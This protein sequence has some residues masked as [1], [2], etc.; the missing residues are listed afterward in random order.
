MPNPESKWD[1]SSIRSRG[2]GV[3]G[4]SKAIADWGEFDLNR[5]Y[6]MKS[7]FYAGMVSA[8]LVTTVMAQTGALGGNTANIERAVTAMQSKLVEQ[9][10][11]IHMH[12]ELGNREVRTS[13]IV[14]ERLRAL[15]FDEV[16]TNVAG[17]G[18]VGLLKGGKPGPVVAVRADMDALPI[19]ETNAVPYKSLVPGVKHACGHDAH[20]TIELGVAEVLS[21]MKDQLPGSVKFIFQPAE[22]GTPPGEEGGAALMIKQGALENPKPL[23]IFGLHVSPEL[24]AGQI[25]F[26]SGAAQASADNMDI[27]LHGKMGHAAHPDRGIDTIVVAAQCVTALQSIK[28][29]RVDTFDPVILTIGTI[30]GGTRRNIMTD[31]VKMEGTLRTFSP[32]VR[33]KVEALVNETLDGVTKAYGATYEVKFEPITSVVYNDPTLV[34]EVLPTIRRVVGATNVVEVTPRMGAE[35]FSCYQEVVPGF[36]YR[37]GSG[38]KAKGITA[39]IHTPGFDIDE[40]CLPVGVKVMSNLVIDFLNDH[41]NKE[42]IK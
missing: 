21:R 33:K 27:V 11:D 10:R 19:T 7:I 32:E 39:D 30:H 41:S 26:C 22:E 4:P 29:R 3:G 24:E 25:G 34:V 35:D 17:H 20:T 36:L 5:G 23:A 8:S 2:E 9:R 18:V 12:P 6:P 15:G 14:A 13:Q 28:S 1:L 37:L 38:N 40:E 31:E 16:R 42:G